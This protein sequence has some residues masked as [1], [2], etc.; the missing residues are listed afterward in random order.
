MRQ[1]LVLYVNGQR[2]EVAGADAFSSLSDYLRNRLRLMGTK[3]V[4]AEGDC[5]SCSVLAGR[6]E[7]GKLVYRAIDSCIQF[8]FQLD[9]A[10]IVTVE[11]LSNGHELSAVQQAMVTHHGSQC[12]YC[13]PGFVVAM[14]GLLENQPAPSEDDWRCGLTGNLCRCTGYTSILAAGTHAASQAHKSLTE[15]YPNEA[16]AAELQLLIQE[17][18]AIRDGSRSV[19]SPTELK[20]A[21]EFLETSPTA[22]I[23]AGGTDVGVQINKRVI[24]PTIFLDLNRLQGLQEISLSS[25]DATG[26][27]RSVL[28]CGVRARWVDLEPVCHE[29]APEFA[30]I[31][32][33]FGSPQI[34]HVGTIGGNI[35]N[36]SPIADSLPFLF[37][38]EAQV[39]IAGPRGV[40]TVDINDFYHGYRQTD[41]KAGELLTGVQIPLPTRAQSLS[42]Y[43]VSRR[44]DLDI[45][46]FTAAILLEVV[47]GQVLE[48]RIALGAV[49]PTV[50]RARQTESYLR[51]KPFTESVM[52]AAGEI[53]VKEISPISDVRGSADFRWQLTRN[54][55]LKFFH[56]R[57]R[58]AAKS[59]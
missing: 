43:K 11:G 31:V 17:P 38:M 42:L 2:H 59:A 54:V 36:G 53:A 56:Q 28:R 20:A 14:T 58:T 23:V 32:S 50:L 55:F 3:V 5:G 51:N 35:V 21:I 1:H 52:Q 47:N 12:G 48:A 18:V 7:S 6:P 19:F 44:R 10:H 57:A 33:V 46:S 49:G 4:C 22:K 9:G 29:H 24:A 13:T 30:E 34:R 16:L 40:R 45:S 39:E 37:A 41:L 26:S 25:K 8:L 15:R 27:S